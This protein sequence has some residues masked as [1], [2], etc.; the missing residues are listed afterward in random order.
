MTIARGGKSVYG[1][2]V[3]V[4]LLDT[5]IPRPVG[6]IGNARTFNFPILYDTVSGASTGLV[7]EQNAS[8]LL[9]RFVEVGQDLVR[10]GVRALS[11]SCGFLSIYQ[12]EMA[13]SI[14]SIVATSA[15]LQIPMVLRMLGP[16]SHVAVLTANA[17]TLGSVHLSAVGIASTDYPRLA[18]IGL[19]GTEH[20]YPTI[21]GGV[22]VPLD[23]TRAESEVVAV[24]K[25]ALADDPAIKAFVLEC[26]N[27]PPYADA[28]REATDVPVWDVTTMLNWIDAAL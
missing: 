18:F 24:A 8:G 22:D 3:G 23:L 19:E 10:R 15:L 6:D 25:K 5:Q 12:R 21:V 28:I 2:S 7:V 27:L 20:F 16:E 17:A 26:T 9:D 1:V 13:T 14:D 11:T 4:M